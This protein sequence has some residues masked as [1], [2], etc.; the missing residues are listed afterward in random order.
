MN[1]RAVALGLL[2]LTALPASASAAVSG[3]VLFTELMIAPATAQPEWIEL[4]NPTGQAVDLTGCQ[5]V[6]DGHEFALDGLVVGAGSFALLSKTDACVIFDAGGACVRQSDL[7]YT[8]VSLNNGD[9]ELL[10]ITCDAGATVVDEVTYEWG[11]FEEDC[12]GVEA[13]SVNLQPGAQT[14]AGNDDWTGAWCVPPS[15]EF[16]WDEAGNIVLA[17]P[18]SA[19]VCPQPGAACAQDDVVFTELMIDPP[20]STREWFELLVTTGSGCDLQGCQL[21]EG[22]HDNPPFFVPCADEP[23]L[24][25]C[26]CAPEDWRCHAID[27]PG[28]TLDLAMGTY[29]LFAKGADT[30]V[31][32][33]GDDGAVFA[34]YR[35]ADVTFGNADPGWM[36]L[37]C[38]EALVESM[39]YDWE[40]FEPGCTGACSINLPPEREDH[41]DNDELNGWCLPPDDASMPSSDDAGSPFF[42]T[43]GEQGVCLTLEWPAAGEVLFTEVMI[44]P[45]EST[46]PEWFE[47]TS[48][49]DRPIELAGC[50]VKRVREDEDAGDDDDSGDDD[51]GPLLDVREY[52]VGS[53]GASPLLE[54]QDSAV[55]VKSK[56]IDGGEAS[57]I[58]TCDFDEQ[59]HYVFGALSFGNDDSTEQL[60][61]HCPQGGVGDPILVDKA[62]YNQKRMGDRKGHSMQF[63]PSQPDAATGNDDYQQWCEASFADCIPG[64]VGE[65][66]ECNFGTPGEAGPC[67]TGAIDVPPSGF[68]CRCDGLSTP[69]RSLGSGLLLAVLGLLLLSVRRRSP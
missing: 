42:G 18:W 66:G 39:P 50:V 68:G 2:A 40:R 58:G 65:D 35:Y 61:L 33:P 37:V 10:Q 19:G 22:P 8:S 9:P 6:D 1:C 5:L 4:L 31:G 32:Q 25:P 27:A 29:A 7:V 12:V 16:V 38:D 45:S 11:E 56:C 13:C 14:A 54:G 59:T 57:G 49:V 63:D 36:H 41:Q 21:W 3:D 28:N 64:T 46:F 60:E 26:F 47:L 69:R 15:S 17:S 52:V 20:T 48:V 51:D 62:V 24:D 67:R 30:V 44:A 23:D 55:F 34:D 53:E 43:P